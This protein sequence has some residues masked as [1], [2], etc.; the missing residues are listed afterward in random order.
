VVGRCEKELCSR[1]AFNPFITMKLAAIIQ[2]D[3]FDPVFSNQANQLPI[4]ASGG[5]IRKFRDDCQ[6]GFSV[7]QGQDTGFSPFP[8]DKI[9]LEMSVF[10]SVPSFLRPFANV[11]LA[12]QYTP[13]IIG[14]ISLSSFLADLP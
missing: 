1:Q 14:S 8:M 2:S 11:P 6:P 12:C 3:G 13:A 7:N 9:P 10:A 4:H 5:F